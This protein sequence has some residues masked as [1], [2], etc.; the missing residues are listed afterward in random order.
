MTGTPAARAV[1][2]SVTEFPDHDGALRLAAGAPDR[3]AENLRVG[4]V[5][6][7]RVLAADRGKA[8]ASCSVSK[9]RFDSHSSLLVQTAS[10]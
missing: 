8:A 5:H 3:C 9:S 7:E 10:R 1:R 4:L 2:M 6:A